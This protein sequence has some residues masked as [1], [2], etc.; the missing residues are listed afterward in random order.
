M[1]FLD[2]IDQ[3]VAV[4]VEAQWPY[5]MINVASLWLQTLAGQSDCQLP[6]LAL[7]DSSPLMDDYLDTVLF[8]TPIL[9]IR[10]A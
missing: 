5:S 6:I 7:S 10:W 2:C 8:H 3:Q 9:W 4:Q 1:P